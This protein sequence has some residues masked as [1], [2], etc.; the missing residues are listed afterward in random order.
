MG[1]KRKKTKRKK[2]L[3]EDAWA[4]KEKEDV[5]Y[6]ASRVCPVVAHQHKETG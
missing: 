2:A 5:E 1:V 3:V 4:V 6:V